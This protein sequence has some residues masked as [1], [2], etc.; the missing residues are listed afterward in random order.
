MPIFG[1]CFG[2][3][4]NS[5]YIDHK[6]RLVPTGICLPLFTGIRYIN[7]FSA[8]N[9]PKI[10]NDLDTHVGG[11]T[12]LKSSTG[13]VGTLR[14]IIFFPSVEPIPTDAHDRTEPASEN[15]F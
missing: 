2:L 8:K 5:K 13:D 15:G 4:N 3:M 6:C 9:Q 10:N 7:Q 14:T 12:I 1:Q 11:L